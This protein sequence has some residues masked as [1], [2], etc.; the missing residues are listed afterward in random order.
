[1]AY[2]DATL[3]DPRLPWGEFEY[4]E[5][6]YRLEELLREHSRASA[7]A[8]RPDAPADADDEWKRIEREIEETALEFAAYAARRGLGVVEGEA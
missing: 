7:L 4:M 8:C 1:M 6:L 5:Y 2:G 3:Q